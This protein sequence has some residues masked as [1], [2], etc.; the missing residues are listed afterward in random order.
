[1]CSKPS[2]I[3]LISSQVRGMSV[4]ERMGTGADMSR[5][6][7]RRGKVQYDFNKPE[8]PCATVRSGWNPNPDQTNCLR[9]P[10]S[11][12]RSAK[13]RGCTTSIPTTTCQ[14][15]KDTTSPAPG[16]KRRHNCHGSCYRKLTA[17]LLGRAVSF[18]AAN[19]C[20]SKTESIFP[21]QVLASV[22]VS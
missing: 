4:S 19:A 2:R 21:T 14:R 3:T 5:C 16:T 10:V 7:L 1:M 9:P 22:L 13:H 6:Q 15:T 12:K 18:D 17:L 20:S 8:T 11:R